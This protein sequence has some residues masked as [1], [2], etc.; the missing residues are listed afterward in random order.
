[1]N[2]RIVQVHG[3]EEI[4]ARVGALASEIS[5]EFGDRELTVLGV[6]EDGF[7]FLADLLRALRVPG[8]H[9]SFVRYEHRSR[10]G[11][12]DL[13]FETPVDVTGREVLVVA[14]VLDTGVTH[15][16]LSKQLEGR[17]AS[18]VRLCVLLDKPDR[19]RTEVR[20]DWHAFA[21]SEEYVFGYGLGLQGRWRELPYLATFERPA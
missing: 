1:M 15:E 5:A 13:S 20:P 9:T 18:S 21:A 3:A 4:A 7:V 16:Y 10:G 12:E 6:Q 2:G 14:G 8:L 17:G 19:R 11:L